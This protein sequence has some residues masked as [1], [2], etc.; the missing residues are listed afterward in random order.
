MKWPPLRRAAIGWKWGQ[1]PFLSVKFHLLTASMHGDSMEVCQGSELPTF[2]G[3]LHH[4]KMKRREGSKKAIL[5]GRQKGILKKAKKAIQPL[6]VPEY[7]KPYEHLDHF[8]IVTDT[9]GYITYANQ[10]LERRTGYRIEEALGKRARDLWGGRMSKDF[11]TEVW[12]SLKEKK[13][14][15]LTEVRNQKKDGTLFYTDLRIYPVLDSAG[16]V[17]AFLGVEVEITERVEELKKSKEAL[18]KAKETQEELAAIAHRAK[19]PANATNL[20]LELLESSHNLTPE[21]HELLRDISGANKDTLE[22]LGNILLMSS[23]AANAETKTF[24]GFEKIVHDIIERHR[25]EISEKGIKIV[26][27]NKAASGHKA[28]LVAQ[29]I[30]DNLISNAIKYSRKDSTVVVAC[31]PHDGSIIFSVSDTGIG[32]PEADQKNIFHQFFRA[33]NVKSGEQR[34]TGVGLHLAQQIAKRLGYTLSFESRK[35]TGTTFFLK[36]PIT[37]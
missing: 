20:L 2:L 21:Q 10:A 13:L 26:F 1:A 22:Y 7:A 4:K 24:T 27:S 31:T 6:H 33:S 34:S 19:S 32:I 8:V 9:D 12:H 18:R 29:E 30:V 23:A 14:P 3:Q 35:N 15:V 11:Y 25:L 28:P 37:A 16:E 17:E 36:M 5:Q